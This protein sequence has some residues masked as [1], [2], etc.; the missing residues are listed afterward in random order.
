MFC[1]FYILFNSVSVISGWLGNEY[2][3]FCA[4]KTH[5]GWDRIR[6]TSRLELMNQWSRHKRNPLGHVGAL[7]KQGLLIP[8]Y[9]ATIFEAV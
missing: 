1:Q 5:I 7:I 8:T 6:R 3:G 9:N 4:M 2:D